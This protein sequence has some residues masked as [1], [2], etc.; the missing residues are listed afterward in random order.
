MS[1]ASLY[2]AACSPMRLH[3]IRMHGQGALVA[4]E[5]DGRYSYALHGFSGLQGPLPM[6][7]RCSRAHVSTQHTCNT[8]SNTSVHAFATGRWKCTV[9]ASSAACCDTWAFP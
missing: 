4:R 3:A 9:G 2:A 8:H 5:K 1:K 6:W 7:R